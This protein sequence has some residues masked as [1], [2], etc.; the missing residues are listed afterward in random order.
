MNT[1]RF[2]K[3]QHKPFSLLTCYEDS[4]NHEGLSRS[5]GKSWAHCEL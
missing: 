1:K 5:N 4:G 2:A 3:L